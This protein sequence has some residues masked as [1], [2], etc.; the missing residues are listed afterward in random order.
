MKILFN[1]FENKSFV[2]IKSFLH[3]DLRKCFVVSKWNLQCLFF[4]WKDDGWHNFS[5]NSGLPG[6]KQDVARFCSNILYLLNHMEDSELAVSNIF[7]HLSR[8]V[9]LIFYFSNNFYRLLRNRLYFE[10]SFS[11]T[12]DL[13]HDICYWDRRIC[14]LGR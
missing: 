10:I 6:H 7:Y 13:W 2:C 8:M 14:S 12:K 1:K 3:L 5:N 11:S 4:S 9:N